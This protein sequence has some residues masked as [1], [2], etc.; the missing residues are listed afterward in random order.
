MGSMTFEDFYTAQVI[1][2]ETMAHEVAAV[3][4]AKDAPEHL[5]VLAGA[6]H[7]RYGYGIPDRAARRGVTSFVTVL[8]VLA[9]DD[10]P[11]VEALVGAADY[12]WVMRP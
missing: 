5:V 4:T 7:V 3:M 10:A 2:D 11:S 12:L 1:W 8:P 9:D 6:G